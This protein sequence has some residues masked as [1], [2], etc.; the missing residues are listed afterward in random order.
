MIWQFRYCATPA[1]VVE[2]LNSLG[3]GPD[4]T[5]KIVWTPERAWTVFYPV[6]R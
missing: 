4:Y 1:E 6:K 2:F 3:N 5:A